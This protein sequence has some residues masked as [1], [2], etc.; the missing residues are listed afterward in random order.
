[1]YTISK[2]LQTCR[3]NIEERRDALPEKSAEQT[4]IATM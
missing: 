1:M 3:E 4:C 2:P